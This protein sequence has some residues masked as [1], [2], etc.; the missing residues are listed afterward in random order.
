MSPDFKVEQKS[1][2]PTPQIIT[3]SR[4]A[5]AVLALISVIAALLLV[6]LPGIFQ[7]A[8]VAVVPAILVGAY[9]MINPFAGVWAFVLM[10]YLRPYTFIAALRPLRLAI[11]TVAATLVSWII[12]QAVR[13]ERIHWNTLS[14]L[15]LC[16]LLIIASTVFTSLN[17]FLA[18]QV[19]EKM[20][21]TFIMFFLTLNI[22]K[23]TTLLYKL[24]W[25]LMLIHL[26]YALKGIYNFAVI[27]YVSAGQ[28]TSGVVGSSFLADENDYALALNTMIPFA[29]FMF[30]NQPNKLRKFFLLVILSAFGMGVVASQSRGGW[31][32]LVAVTVFCILKS[33]QKVISLALVGFMCLAVVVF[34]PSSYWSEVSSITDTGEATAQSRLNYWKAAGRMFLDYPLTGVGAGNGPIQMPNYVTGF[35]DPATQWGRTFH[36]T[37]PLVIAE[38]GG[39]GL[40]TYLVMLLVATRCLIKVQK[41][42]RH[43]HKSDEWTIASA[44]AGSFI[45]YMTSAT[46]LSTAYYPQLWTLYAFTAGLVI[47]VETSRQGV[48]NRNSASTELPHA[49]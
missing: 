48:S 6:R 34:A 5:I 49:Q 2:L 29:F 16:F 44:L 46:F 11:L 45:G 15:F 20:V 18:Y 47:S 17:N 14:T 28:V 37:L 24:I 32:G 1:N 22:A 13:K 42:F 7:Y 27:G 23:S 9:I 35:R 41:Q 12:H 19:F 10:E 4:I 39:L 25:M 43:D 30:Q 36:G 40:L 8:M 38:T 33:K 3:G 26:Y 21:V 31:V